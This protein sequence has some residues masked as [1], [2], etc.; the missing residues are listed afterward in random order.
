MVI[1]NYDDVVK[2][3]KDIQNIGEFEGVCHMKLTDEGEDSLYLVF[4]WDDEDGLLG[5]IAYNCDDLMCDF[6]WDWNIPTNV[7][8]DDILGIMLPHCEN[9]K[10]DE[11]AIDFLECLDY[12]LKVWEA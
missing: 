4:G 2:Y 8:T 12:I 11:L 1:V 10:A 6:D 5:K 3:I 7:K 9:A